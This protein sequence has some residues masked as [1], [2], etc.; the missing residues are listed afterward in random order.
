MFHLLG[1]HS[2]PTPFLLFSCGACLLVAVL[3]VIPSACRTGKLW[4]A[5]TLQMWMTLQRESCGREKM[6]DRKTG[7]RKPTRLMS[8]SP[9]P[10]RSARLAAVCSVVAPSVCAHACG[11]VHA[12]DVASSQTAADLAKLPRQLREALKD[13]TNQVT[14]VRTSSCRG[15]RRAVCGC[16][17]V[18]T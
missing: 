1:P 4:Q 5:R 8:F 13:A 6:L 7:S 17:C 11:R 2:H 9:G 14:V 3:C 16:G 10:R 15:E 12:D 18:P